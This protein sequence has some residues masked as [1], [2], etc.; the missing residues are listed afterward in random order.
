MSMC[1]SFSMIVML[2]KRN[3]NFV[4]IYTRS[5]A[6]FDSYVEKGTLLQN[7]AH[8]FDLLIRLRQSV[9]H[10]YLVLY[11]KEKEA[12]EFSGKVSEQNDTCICGICHEEVENLC[13]ARCK[14]TFCLE[15]IRE[16]ISTATDGMEIQC[17]TCFVPISVDLS[18]S[19]QEQPT[20]KFGH[21]NILSKVNLSRFQSST[22]VEALME[23][24]Y[25]MLER[26]SNAKG[27]VFSQFVSM[28]DI[29]EYRLQ[30]GGIKV[31]KLIGGMTVTAR[32]RSIDAFKN[33]PSIK[34]FLISLKAGGVALN[35]TAASSIFLMDP[36]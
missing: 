27:I 19:K 7:Y 12:D 11:S 23:E 33:D 2:F 30:K 6:Q 24:V 13:V 35:L 28:L 17:P 32:D 14:D 22:K 18:G 3:L 34:I 20:K 15:C 9:D 21:R 4:A 36:W 16:Y 1:R 10:P 29:I 8:I 26:D 31:V 25:M 5:R